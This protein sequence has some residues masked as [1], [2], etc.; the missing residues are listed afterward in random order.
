VFGAPLEALS[1]ACLY[2]TPDRWVDAM[3]RFGEAGA[4]HVL[5]L[6]VTDDLPAAVDLVVDEVLPQVAGTQALAGA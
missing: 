2:G 4:D 6:L 1:F 5:T 3:G